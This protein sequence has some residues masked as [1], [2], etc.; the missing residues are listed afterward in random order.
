MRKKARELKS[1]SEAELKSK[2][3]ELE[4]ELVKL[5]AQVATGTALKSPGQVRETRR[6]IARIYTMLRSKSEV[7]KTNE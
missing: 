6:G 4:K 1:L 2:L 7:K 5:R 3:N